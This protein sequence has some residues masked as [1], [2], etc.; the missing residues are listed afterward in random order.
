MAT[1]TAD[2]LEGISAD[3]LVG[4]KFEDASA[5]QSGVSNILGLAL[6]SRSLSELVDNSFEPVLTASLK[7]CKFPFIFDLEIGK[8]TTASKPFRDQARDLLR[9]NSPKEF[10]IVSEN[11]P[12]RVLIKTKP[13]ASKSEMEAFQYL[14]II[15]PFP[16]GDPIHGLA[17]DGHSKAAAVI[18][19]AFDYENKELDLKPNNLFSQLVGDRITSIWA[20][21]GVPDT[22]KDR[23]LIKYLGMRPKYSRVSFTFLVDDAV[24]DNKV[25]LV[26]LATAFPLPDSIPANKQQAV[27]RSVLGKRRPPEMLTGMIPKFNPDMLSMKFWHDLVPKLW[28]SVDLVNLMHCPDLA[29]VTTTSEAEVTSE[30]GIQDYVKDTRSR[31]H[32][33]RECLES[34]KEYLEI[35]GNKDLSD[36]RDL[37]L[38]TIRVAKDLPVKPKKNK[39]L[40]IKAWKGMNSDSLLE[41]SAFL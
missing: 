13:G 25:R 38:A 33:L 41:N 15:L 8:G 30:K 7:S 28:R 6:P 5:F 18:W 16:D 32:A 35:H 9:N 1:A 31:F 23:S 29:G 26:S 11:F 14:G 10:G 20:G 36:E 24:E 3:S 21:K 40:S 17:P 34:N 39:P 12:S 4:H 37:A 22:V 19:M 27:V 2:P